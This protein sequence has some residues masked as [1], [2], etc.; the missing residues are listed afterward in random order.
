MAFRTKP[1]LLE[2]F[3]SVQGVLSFLRA[4]NAP[5]PKD[6][7]VEKWFQRASIPSD[8]F[9]ILL[10]YLELDRG[11]PISLTDYMEGI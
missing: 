4:Y 8:W 10:V 6:K 2:H 7:A 9:P 11:G 3:G 5:L 1:F